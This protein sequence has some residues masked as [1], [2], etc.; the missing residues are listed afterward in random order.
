MLIP[1]DRGQELTSIHAG[2]IQIEQDERGARRLRGIGKATSPVEI[3]ERFL[4]PRA[5]G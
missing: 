5:A 3:I 1:L 2:Q 4:A